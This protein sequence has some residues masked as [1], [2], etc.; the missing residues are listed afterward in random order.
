MSGRLTPAQIAQVARAAGFIGAGL[1]TAVAVA[2]AESGGNPRAVH[3]NADKYRSRDRGLWQINDHWHPEVSDAA[4]FDP[5]SAAAA[6]YR[7]SGGGRSW[8]AWSTYK[9]GAAAKQL[10][11][12]RLAASAATAQP[13]GFWGDLG[14]DLVGGPTA[15]LPKN[16]QPKITPPGVAADPL[17]PLKDAAKGLGQLGS[18]T[19]LAA[20]GGAWVADPH[21]WTRV[22]L[23]TGGGVAVLLGLSMVAKSG[24]AGSNAASIAAIPG[25]A[26][27]TASKAAAAAALA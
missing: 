2:L 27:H 3:V 6:A 4:A 20:K 10:G 9:S 16:L 26:A 21:N 7:I 18:L 12:A 14:K 22:L 23:V 11:T 25:R 13:A 8:S 5:A 17:A 15:G 19:L 24:A 1:V